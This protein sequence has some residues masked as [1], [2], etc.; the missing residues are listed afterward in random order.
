M[1]E[2][3]RSD[4]RNYEGDLTRQGLWVMLRIDLVDGAIRS[5][6]ARCG[7]RYQLYKMLKL[8]SQ[9]MTGIDLPRSNR[10]EAVHD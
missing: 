7:C 5:G 1:F 2:N 6:H 3:I 4:W 9:I 10:G 8:L